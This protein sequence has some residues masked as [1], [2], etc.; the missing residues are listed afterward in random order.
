MKPSLLRLLALVITVLC[1]APAAAAVV[2]FD[3]RGSIAG[4]PLDGQTFGGHFSIELDESGAWGVPMPFLD[5]EFHFNG[6]THDE[7]DVPARAMVTARGDLVTLFG[8]AC[9]A[10]HPAF[11]GEFYCELPSGADSWYFSGM[12]GVGA[13]LS[14]TL[15]STGATVHA[16]SATLTRREATP[17]PEPATAWL[18]VSA[19][20]GA[21]FARRR[22]ARVPPQRWLSG[23][24]LGR[25]PSW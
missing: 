17:V 12:D 11:P 6:H 10:P 2:T 9:G 20:A 22:H 8:P 23:S 21:A 16:A 24:A 4:S 7:G 13:E 14:F 5:L 25:S 1:G 18:V 3:I 19:W 15:A